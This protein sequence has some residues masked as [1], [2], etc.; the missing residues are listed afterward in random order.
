MKLYPLALT[1]VPYFPVG[2]SYNF[3]LARARDFPSS[4]Q[5]RTHFATFIKSPVYPHACPSDCDRRIRRQFCKNHG[6]GGASVAIRRRFA[7]QFCDSREF[8]SFIL[9]QNSRYPCRSVVFLTDGDTHGQ[10]YAPLHWPWQKINM[11][12]IRAKARWGYI[13]RTRQRGSQ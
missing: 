4:G 9:P 13:S 1:L 10:V 2:P 5:C 8:S 6:G 11:S 7:V 12:G 3:Y